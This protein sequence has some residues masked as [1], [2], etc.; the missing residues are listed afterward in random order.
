MDLRQLSYFLEV[1]EHES[2]SKAS[3]AIHLSQPTLSKMVKGLEEELG[4]VLFNR[5]TRSVM[6]TEAGKVV[7]H[8]AQ[9]VMNA[10][11]NLQTAVADLTQLKAG[12][13]T[14]GL[15]PVI[16]ASFFPKVITEFR[17]RHP[18]ITIQLVEEGGKR[19]EQLLQEGRLDLGVVV[20]PVDD[21]LFEIVPIVK[22][23]LK[24]V[25]PIQHHLALGQEV[26]LGDLRDESFILFRHEFNLHDRVKEA[27]IQ[28][29]F[30]P[31]VAYE[32]SQWDF[33]YELICANQGISLLP[34][35]ICAKFDTQ[36]VRVLNGVE[37]SIHWNLGIVWKKDGYLSHAAR[38]WVEYVKEVFS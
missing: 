29:G 25:V 31:Q 33:I 21:A 6:L 18:M 13:F 28:E 17:N 24:L 26:K 7:Q 16:G 10:A 22:R 2:F 32:S 23:Q 5:S 34:E 36:K 8:H 3:R 14:L 19:I 35:T 20:L 27:C 15:P 12:K 38:G 11:H 9:A 4:V 1:A 37:P 30:E